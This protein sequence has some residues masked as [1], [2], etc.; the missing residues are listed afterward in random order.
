MSS[1]IFATPIF[2][3]LFLLLPF[4]IY[5]ELKIKKYPAIKFSSIRIIKVVKSKK[6][7]SPKIILLLL[8]VLTLSFLIF[9]LARPQ[10]VKNS[11][12]I[13]SEGI[14]MMLAIDTSGSMQAI[15]MQ[16]DKDTV[17]RLDVVKNVVRDF[18]VNRKNDPT[19][20]IVFGTE[21]YTQCP[22][23]LD[24][25]ILNEFVNNLDIGVA[26]EQTSIGNALSLAVNRLKELKAKSK[27]VILL[28]DGAN[29]AGRI[30]PDK[31]VEIAKTFN[32]KVYTV[33]VG[34]TG[35]IPF[36]QKTPF[37][38][39]IVYGEADLDEKTLKM[40]ADKTSGKYYRAK[41]KEELKKIYQDIDKLEKSDVKVKNYLD[42][43]EVFYYFLIPA[44][45]TLLLEVFLSNTRFLR[46]P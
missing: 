5:Y 28:T 3:S 39:Q 23:T 25:N 21:A 14:N 1:F 40:I 15:D 36:I 13:M 33:G 18:V 19:G 46:I 41:N 34:T 26:G 11:T 6:K 24:T 45:I 22:L 4:F 8:R 32:V 7:F 12:E 35:K 2:F 44:L 30:P 9:A 31:A 29:T 16:I 37:G 42:A 20:L 17:T 43:K 27:V 10:I 38:N